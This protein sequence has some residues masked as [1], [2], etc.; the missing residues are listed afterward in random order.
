MLASLLG[1]LHVPSLG[2][3]MTPFSLSIAP[4]SSKRSGSMLKSPP[5][6]HCIAVASASAPNA[7][8]AARFLAVG[9]SECHR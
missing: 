9:P 7:A 3:T 5:S 4:V 2:R 1:T 6:T 8:S